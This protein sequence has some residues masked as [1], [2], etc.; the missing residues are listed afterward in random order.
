MKKFKI[1]TGD[2]VVVI[3]GSEKGRF[4]K[5]IKMIPSESRIVVSGVNLASKHVKPSASSDGGIISLEMPLHIS[6]VALRDPDTGRPTKV[7]FSTDGDMKVRISKKSGKQ[8]KF[9]RG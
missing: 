3:S 7:K 9:V 5:V 6:N 2:E 1:R 4:G 8:I